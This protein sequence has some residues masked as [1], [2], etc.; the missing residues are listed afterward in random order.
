VSFYEVVFY[1]HLVNMLGDSKTIRD[2]RKWIVPLARG[3]MLEMGVHALNATE[4]RAP[5]MFVRCRFCA[6]VART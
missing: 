4:I 1:P 3:T 6:C 5:P 2:V